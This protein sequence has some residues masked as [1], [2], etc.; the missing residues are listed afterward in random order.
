MDE[1]F[2]YLVFLRFNTSLEFELGGA[3][4]TLDEALNAK[5]EYRLMYGHTVKVAMDKITIGDM[6]SVKKKTLTKKK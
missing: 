2:V 1:Q 6:L 3:F 5:E 4:N